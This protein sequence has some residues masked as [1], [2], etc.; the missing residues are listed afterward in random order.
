MPALE[1][2]RDQL[3]DIVDVLGRSRLDLRHRHSQLLGVRPERRQPTAC[4][5]L[6][7]GPG[8]CGALDDLVV[9]VRD[10]HDPADPETASTQVA[11]QDVGEEETAEVADVR[12]PYTVGPQL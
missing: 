5:L 11:D 7:R 4:L 8:G 1:E 10:V 12:G 9:D 6:N 3:D 2:D